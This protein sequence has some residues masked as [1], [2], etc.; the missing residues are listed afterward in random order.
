MT[1]VLWFANVLLLMFLENNKS[2]REYLERQDSTRTEQIGESKKLIKPETSQ[3]T[4]KV[5]NDTK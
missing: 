1:K 4:K 3:K 2:G 5:V